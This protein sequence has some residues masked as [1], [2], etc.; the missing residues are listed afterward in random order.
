ML[1]RRKYCILILSGVSQTYLPCFKVSLEDGDS[2]GPYWNPAC[3]AIGF[4]TFN[5]LCI[6]LNISILEGLMLLMESILNPLG[7]RPPQIARDTSP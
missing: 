2:I 5:V 6:D 3:D 1:N 4:L 7:L